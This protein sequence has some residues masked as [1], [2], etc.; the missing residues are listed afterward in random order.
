MDPEVLGPRSSTLSH[1]RR[2]SGRRRARLEA[3]RFVIDGPTLLAEALASDIEVLE[4]YAE[5]DAPADVLATARAAGV[6]VR[7]IA[8]GALAKATSPVTP[9]PVAA[10]A[11]LPASPGPSV[12]RGLVLVLVGVADPGNA[13]TIVRVAEASGASA[14][15]SCADAV[16][17]WNPKS[18]RASAGSLFRVPILVEGDASDALALLHQAGMTTVATTLDPTAALLDDVD[19][20]GDVAVLLGNE[21]H[22]LPADVVAGA[23]LAVRIPMAGR[24]ESLNVAATGTVLAFEA[25]RQ[26]RS[27]GPVR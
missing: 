21:A 23:D 16:D 20:R 24:V 14:V 5:P 26:R 6:P 22:G 17:L 25:A 8:P 1:L 7:D 19:L 4:V 3:G 27:G 11:A 10:L 2:L 15:V 12:L 13:G 9:Q 18:V